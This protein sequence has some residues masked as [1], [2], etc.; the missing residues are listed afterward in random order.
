MEAEGPQ[1]AE[2][3]VERRQYRRVRL[4][5]QVHCHALE[6]HEMLVT[7]DVSVGGMFINVQNPLPVDSD[8]SLTFRLDPAQPAITCRAKVAFS[9]N[10]LG[11]GVQ[12]LDLSFD[13]RQMIQAFVDKEG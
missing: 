3:W 12:F 4:V 1:L 13:L 11:M 5:T 7:R 2:A 8:L 10:G 6:R 9:R